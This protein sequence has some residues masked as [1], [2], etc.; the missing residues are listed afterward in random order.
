MSQATV[1]AI[2]H[3]HRQL[4][5]GV[6]ESEARA[7][8]ANALSAAGLVNGGCLTLF[9]GKLILVDLTSHFHRTR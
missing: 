2:R 6:K 8:M 9:G 7:M 5:I 1:L 3:V 4:H